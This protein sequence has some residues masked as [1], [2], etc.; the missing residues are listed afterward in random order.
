[1]KFGNK[2]YRIRLAVMAQNQPRRQILACK[3]NFYTLTTL[4]FF[5][6]Q[7][8]TVDRVCISSIRIFPV[9]L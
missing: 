2:G 9:F 4:Y 5:L 3:L 6:L 1:M 8:I 7:S